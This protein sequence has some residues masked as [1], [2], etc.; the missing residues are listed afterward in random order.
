[1]WMLHRRLI[2]L[3]GEGTLLDEALYDELWEE[4]SRRIRALGVGE[5]SVNIVRI[6]AAAADSLWV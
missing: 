1:M 6:L 3:G 2:M 4:T 5:M